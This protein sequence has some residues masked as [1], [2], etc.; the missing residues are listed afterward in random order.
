MKKLFILTLF[1]IAAGIAVVIKNSI[2]DPKTS[3]SSKPVV[4]IGIIYPMSGDGAIFGETARE[5]ADMFFEEFNKKN[6]LFDYQ[7]IFEDNQMKLDKNASLANKLIQVDK[8]DVLVTCL[9]NFGA[10]VSPIAERNKT[11]HFSV[12]TDPIV[13]EGF[14]NFMASS[15]VE[16]EAGLLYDTLISNG[17]RNVDIVVVNATG[18]MSMIKYFED[19]VTKDKGLLIGNKYSVNADEKDF[20]TL[21]SKIKNNNPDYV[22]VMLAFPTI[23]VFLKQYKDAGVNIPFTGIETF[24]YLENKALAE[25]QWYVDAAPATSEFEAALEAKTGKTATNYGEYMNL[26]LQMITLGFEGAQ[27]KDKAL[28]G[29]YILQNS[30]GSD[31]AIGIVSTKP[32]GIIDGQPVIRKII[33]AQT[34]KE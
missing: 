9:S 7:I 23:D 18:P 14:Y 6:P 29:E 24:T 8:V 13:A 25:G 32:E 5:V 1:I 16:G 31:T 2:S 12:A 33:N 17:A 28:V 4:K 11:L 10:V 22:I 26:I 27:S 34:M 15:N 30:N 19:K 20:R 3:A 21:I